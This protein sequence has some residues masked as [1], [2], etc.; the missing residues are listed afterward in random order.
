MLVMLGCGFSKAI[1]QKIWIFCTEENDAS[2]LAVDCLDVCGF[3]FTI[4]TRDGLGESPCRAQISFSE[5]IQNSRCSLP[6]LL[7][8]VA[9]MLFFP[10]QPAIWFRLFNSTHTL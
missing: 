10:R 5:T 9:D 1:Q 7:L 4:I 6:T 8:W 2:L 3:N